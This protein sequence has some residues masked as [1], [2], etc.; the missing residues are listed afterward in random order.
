M[1]AVWTA[2]SAGYFLYDFDVQLKQLREAG[3]GPGDVADAA[4]VLAR[5]RREEESFLTRWDPHRSS[6]R[7]VRRGLWIGFG[8]FLVTGAWILLYGGSRADYFAVSILAAASITQIMRL[9]AFRHPPR[10][11][12]SLTGRFWRSRFVGSRWRRLVGETPEPR[13]DLG[14]RPTEIRLGLT[15]DALF[16]ALPLDVRRQLRE[17]LP[18]VRC[19]EARTQSVRRRIEELDRLQAQA[20]RGGEAG[21][22]LA[23]RTAL[24]TVLGASRAAA[25]ARLEQLVAALE[26]IRLDLLRLRAR[27]ATIEGI[28]ADLAAAAEMA[29][30]TERLL[31]AQEEVE[32][33]T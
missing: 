2:V 17:V 8:L 1:A 22:A 5:G 7:V 20:G 3:Y 10:T 32:R 21:A 14:Y 31:A 13:G 25:E 30:Q 19:L 28:T 4:D 9:E 18:L 12:K 6:P 24:L 29:A 26:T 16:A 27:A 33:P 15:V 11:W 23:D